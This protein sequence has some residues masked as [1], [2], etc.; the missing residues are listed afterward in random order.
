MLY[1]VWLFLSAIFFY[2]AYI[3][4]R[5][6]QSSLREFQFRQKEGEEAPREV[7]A[8]TKEFVADFNRYLQSVNSA[9]RAR[10]RAAAFGFM[11]GG[12]VALVSMFMTLP[13]S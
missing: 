3:N 2:Y 12:V 4:W 13:I 10:H 5:Q 9:N 1:P 6:A 8:G 7:D 11:V